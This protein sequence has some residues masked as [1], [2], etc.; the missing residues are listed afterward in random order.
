MNNI[1]SQNISMVCQDKNADFNLI[2]HNNHIIENAE[3]KNKIYITY[4]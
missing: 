4:N 3:R 2:I 1:K